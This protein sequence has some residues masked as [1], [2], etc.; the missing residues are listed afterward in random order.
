MDIMEVMATRRSSFTPN[1]ELIYQQVTSDPEA[2]AT[3][4]TT[5]LAQRCGV[6][7]PALTRFVKSL[8]YARYQGFRASLIS[9]LTEQHLSQAPTD[10]RL[11]YFSRFGQGLSQLESLLT[12]AFMSD[13]ASYISSFDRVFATGVAKSMQP[14]R[15]LEQ[16]MVKSGR[17]VQAFDSGYLAE[18]TD[19]MTDRDLMIV[20][21]VGQRQGAFSTLVDSSGKVLLCTA[22]AEG[23]LGEVADRMIVFPSAS[24][25]PEE[26]S[27]SP[28]MFDM[29]VELLVAYLM[30][31]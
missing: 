7:Q 5:A 22:T 29:F 10:G 2:V 3:L 19:A 23:P 12:D 16:L 21:S 11:A 6:S 25:N 24:R 30:R 17:I 13:L 14:A 27:V 4:T 9:W 1:D 8:G 20:F 26:G 18:V 31:R 28:I 15:L